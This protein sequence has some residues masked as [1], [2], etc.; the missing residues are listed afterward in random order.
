MSVWVRLP[1]SLISKQL[2]IQA[3]ESGVTF[4]SGDHFYSSSPQQNMMRL[5]FTMATS[6]AIEE[7][8]KRLG[9]LMKARLVRI[10]KQRAQDRTDGLRALV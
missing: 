4:I 8:V 10:K 5:S 7:A 6:Q 1:D 9:T 3:L 2:L